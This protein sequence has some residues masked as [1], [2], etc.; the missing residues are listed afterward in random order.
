MNDYVVKIS[1]D[2]PH[3]YVSTA[4]DSYSQ[5][6]RNVAI[7]SVGEQSVNIVIEMIGAQEEAKY[8]SEV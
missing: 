1:H 5:T 2:G 6:I 4:P 3:V 8:N 7:P